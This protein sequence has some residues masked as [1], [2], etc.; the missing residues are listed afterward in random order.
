MEVPNENSEIDVM[1]HI[2]EIWTSKPFQLY[3]PI[4]DL[5]HIW[6]LNLIV[7]L[8]LINLRED[9]EEKEVKLQEILSEL[10]DFTIEHF[11]VEE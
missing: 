10:I 4:L 11:S 9:S 3:I 1:N 2:K 6:L 7:Q 5:Q 8:E